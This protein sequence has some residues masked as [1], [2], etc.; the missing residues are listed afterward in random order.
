MYQAGSNFFLPILFIDCVPSVK[1]KSMDR[2][3]RVPHIE[4]LEK[5]HANRGGDV[6]SESYCRRSILISPS[7]PSGLF[8]LAVVVC[9]LFSPTLIP[10]PTLSLSQHMLNPLNRVRPQSFT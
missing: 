3:Y 8:R 7:L 4:E 9:L 5:R 6:D 2:K 1:V 10:R